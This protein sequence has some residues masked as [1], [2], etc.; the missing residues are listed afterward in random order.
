MT[1]SATF[2]NKAAPK[3]AKDPISDMA[4]YEYTLERTI[5]Y[6]SEDDRVLEL[7]CGTG[8]TAL[9]LAP[10]VREIVGTDLSDAMIGIAQ[11]KAKDEGLTNTDFR[12]ASA[13]DAAKLKEPFDAVLGHN[14]FHLVE[15]AE[16]IFSDVYRMLPA[17]GYFIQK[18]PCL[19]DKAFGFKRFPIRAILPL[20]QLFGKA[21]YVRFMSQP[22]LENALTFAGFEIV[23]AG[24][25]PA[26]SRY[27]VAKRT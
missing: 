19:G 16:S 12:V 22:D 7:G 17:G 10:H 3:Y 15:D 21:P 2:W 20:M 25:F 8:S 18:T 5:S 4:A 24:N 14:L 11:D 6:L 26:E 27:I 1:D 13:A 9:L 23:E